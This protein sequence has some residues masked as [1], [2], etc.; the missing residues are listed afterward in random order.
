M[1]VTIGRLKL[2]F[3]ESHEQ[4]LATKL[5]TLVTTRKQSEQIAT[6]KVLVKSTAVLE[7]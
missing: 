4:T 2:T 3:L 1:T 6:R 5:P 7:T